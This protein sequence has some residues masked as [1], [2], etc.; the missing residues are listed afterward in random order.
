[1]I[2]S[3]QSSQ[4]RV[5]GTR[6]SAAVSA[7]VSHTH[8]HTYCTLTSSFV[9]CNEYYSANN[10]RPMEIKCA[11]IAVLSELRVTDTQHT[12]MSCTKRHAHKSRRTKKHQVRGNERSDLKLSIERASK[13]FV[14]R[15]KPPVRWSVFLF[16]LCFS[17]SG[18]LV[19]RTAGL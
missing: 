18:S 9:R 8:T 15:E 10:V 6:R 2:F 17:S 14:G 16:V 13:A 1:M 4:V 11:F 7:Q 3:T 5:S 19:S 12:G